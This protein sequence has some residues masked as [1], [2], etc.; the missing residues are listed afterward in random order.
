VL[1]VRSGAHTRAGMTSAG[2]P[3]QLSVIVGERIE[4][5]QLGAGVCNRADPCWP[6]LLAVI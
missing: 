3:L 4:Q 5:D 2:E 1:L 6:I